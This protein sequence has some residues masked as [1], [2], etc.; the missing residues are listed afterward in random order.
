[1]I[2]WAQGIW[3]P[4]QRIWLR[5]GQRCFANEQSEDGDPCAWGHNNAAGTTLRCTTLHCTEL[6]H[7]IYTGTAEDTVQYSIGAQQNKL[8]GCDCACGEVK[9][10]ATLTAHAS[11]VHL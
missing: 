5:G 1:M 11:A 10:S 6:Q 3:P 2:G 7:Y 8:F 4:P 9:G